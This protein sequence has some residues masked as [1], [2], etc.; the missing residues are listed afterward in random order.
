MLGS[1]PGHRW[2]MRWAPRTVWSMMMVSSLLTTPMATGFPVRSLLVEQGID[3][4]GRRVALIGAG[5]AACPVRWLRRSA[6]QG[7]PTLQISEPHT[8]PGG[9]CRCSRWPG[10]PGG[11]RPM[12][13]RIARRSSCMRTSLGMAVDDPLPVSVDHLHAGRNWR[14]GSR[15][16]SSAA[17]GAADIG[18]SLRSDDHQRGVAMLLH[19]AAIQ[20]ELWTGEDAPIEGEMRRA[21]YRWKSTPWLETTR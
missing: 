11:G 19:Q 18:R 5:G 13:S 21:V 9:R 2:S 12:R 10:G 8:R 1:I 4:S 3:L 20:L 16:P 15:L 6:G 17:H 7:S 14:R